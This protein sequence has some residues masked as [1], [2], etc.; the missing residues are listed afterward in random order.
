M[1]PEPALRGTR[2]L[3]RPPDHSQANDPAALGKRIIKKCDA[4]RL[5]PCPPAWPM[6]RVLCDGPEDSGYSAAFRETYDT[7]VASLDG[8]VRAF[9]GTLRTGS[10]R[11]GTLLDIRESSALPGPKVHAYSG[12]A[13]DHAG[14]FASEWSGFAGEENH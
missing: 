12:Q 10:A 14:A 2:Q 8:Q 4:A 1:T 11:T 13:L 9:F 7:F 5:K 3:S 6:G